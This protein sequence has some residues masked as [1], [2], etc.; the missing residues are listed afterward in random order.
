MPLDPHALDLI[1]TAFPDASID[2]LAPTSGGFSHQSTYVT[3]DG[4][5]C[6]VKA[7]CIAHR[8]AALRH[9]AHILQLLRGSGLPA[10]TLLALAED[11]GWTI[12]VQGFV[13][14]THGLQVLAERPADLE[15][16]YDE[17]G[18]LLA[19]IH[20]AGLAAP[21]PEPRSDTA[22][23]TL[24]ALPDLALDAGLRE[25]LAASLAHSAW[26]PAAPR[27]VHGDAG[28][29]NLLWDGRITALL[30]WEW[31]GCGPPL[32]DLAWVYW[33]MRW[34]SLPIQLWD[35]FLRAYGPGPAIAAG[36]VPG[37][38]RA[39]ALG[40]VACILANSRYEPTA[41]A[42]WLRRARWT[43]A[44]DIPEICEQI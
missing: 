25:E 3:I 15:Q 30:D 19:A 22:I 34:R 20:G 38:L 21:D 42:E 16:I 33:T 1:A 39:L 41:W 13:A 28:L 10:P 36:G 35:T 24:A 43:L 2:G 40:Q 44:L 31:A 26:R 23:A 12:E 6:V 11:D 8:R 5:R 27:L 9:E 37:E 18:R 17:L 14:G 29:H 32:L 7:A 4:R